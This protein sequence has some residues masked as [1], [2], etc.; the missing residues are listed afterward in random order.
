MRALNFTA[1]PRCEVSTDMQCMTDL[2]SVFGGHPSLSLQFVLYL[3]NS[4]IHLD[5]LYVLH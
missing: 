4:N 3:L 1:Q 2:Q 5:Y